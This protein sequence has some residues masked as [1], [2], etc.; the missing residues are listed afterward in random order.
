MSW[1]EVHSPH[2]GR[3]VRVRDK[4][5]GRSVRDGD[6]RIFFVIERSDGEGYYGSVTRQGGPEHEAKYDEMLAKEE[7]AKNVAADIHAQQVH[8]ATGGKRSSARGKL[9]ILLLA[10]IVLFLVWLFTIGPL[11]N[12]EWQ[13]PPGPNNPPT[14]DA[15]NTDTL[16][17]DTAPKDTDSSGKDGDA[18]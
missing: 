15:A 9:V 14:K 18:K 7:H 10:A 13:A 11:G 1:L 4:D 12:L 8:D 16:P 3:P 2:D 6:G 5:I 17:K